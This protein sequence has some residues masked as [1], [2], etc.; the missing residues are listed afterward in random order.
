MNRQA[1]SLFIEQN[2]VEKYLIEYRGNL[3]EQMKDID[4]A[5]AFKITDKLAILAIK[6]DRIDELKKAVPAIIFVNFRNKYVLQD[7]RRDIILIL[8]IGIMVI[9]LDYVY[10]FEF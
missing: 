2:D 4:Y 7:T 3:L 5:C 1:C 10:L 8:V 6:D 9:F